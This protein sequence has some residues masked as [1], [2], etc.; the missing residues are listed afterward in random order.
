MYQRNGGS[1]TQEDQAG[2]RQ[3]AGE[4]RE[5]SLHEAPSATVARRGRMRPPQ[6]SLS[7]APLSRG[8]RHLEVD[9]PALQ[10]DGDGMRSIVGREL[11]EDV[12]DVAL[13]GFFGDREL[14]GDHLVRVP[15]GNEPQH[16]DFAR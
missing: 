13:D 5:E 1:S 7:R 2:S 9:D 4:R 15:A 14:S 3:T 16:L 8:W 6:K 10:T 12:L 11:G